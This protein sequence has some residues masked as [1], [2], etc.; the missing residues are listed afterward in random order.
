MLAAGYR[1]RSP[2]SLLSP[3]LDDLLTARGQRLA[4]AIRVLVR[5]VNPPRTFCGVRELIVL[6]DEPGLVR[7]D[8]GGFALGRISF[9]SRVLGHYRW[10]LSDFGFR[11]RQR[12]LS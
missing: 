8:V 6:S 1:R 9:P 2:S 10:V 5:R 3:A 7:S 4:G 11:W 12:P